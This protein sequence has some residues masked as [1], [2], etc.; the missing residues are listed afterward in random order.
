MLKAKVQ[1][2]PLA[3]SSRIVALDNIGPSCRGDSGG[4]VG[5]I[6]CDDEHTVGCPQLLFDGCQRGQQSS[7]L[8]VSWHQNCNALAKIVVRADTGR[9]LSAWQ[10]DRRD[11]LDEKYGD[12]DS[13]K[14][15]ANHQKHRD[16][17]LHLNNLWVRS[18]TD[19][20]KTSAGGTANCDFRSSH[21]RTFL[22]IPNAS[23][24]IRILR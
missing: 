11:H 19:V 24:H 14:S 12:W 8:I 17:S 4:V 1:G 20:V 13:D 21:S 15:G 5:A 2:I 16:D 23:S 6:I 7:A 3:A 18:I 22:Q 9:G 10:Y